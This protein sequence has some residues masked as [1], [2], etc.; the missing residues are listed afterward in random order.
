MADVGDS[1]EVQ[2]RAIRLIGDPAL[3]CHLQPL[4]HRRAVGDL[5]LFYL[6]RR[7]TRLIGD[8]AL[9]AIFSRFLTGVLLV[10]S[11]FTNVIQTDSA[12]MS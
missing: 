10:T 6:Q 9:I 3:T 5:S 4:S 12:P 1:I 8:P 2:R 7:A 11:H